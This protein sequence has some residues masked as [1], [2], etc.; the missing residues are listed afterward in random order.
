MPRRAPAPQVQ[1]A[2]RAAAG[3]SD[4][5]T[6]AKGDKGGKYKRH[7]R[8]KHD[9]ARDRKR[10]RDGKAYARKV[11]WDKEGAAQIRKGRSDALPDLDALA[12]AEAGR[13]DDGKGG[14]R[15]EIAP[16]VTLIIW[17]YYDAAASRAR[18]R[19]RPTP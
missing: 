11:S 19:L 4:E 8:K 17:N 9:P 16:I 15:L 10:G 3:R 5:D 14:R 2:G 7:G 12:A 18:R 1:C 6:T 13:L